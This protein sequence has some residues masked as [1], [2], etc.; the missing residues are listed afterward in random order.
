VAVG[1]DFDRVYTAPRLS[2]AAA[3]DWTIYAD[4]S[5]FELFSDGGLTV[6]TALVFPS[7]PYTQML[8][9]S[10]DGGL[11]ATFTHTPLDGIH[12]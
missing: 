9:R 10:P 4:A 3:I 5:S 6:M 1:P 12:N 8:L 2:K 7:H 11:A